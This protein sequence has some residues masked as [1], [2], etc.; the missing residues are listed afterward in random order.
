MHHTEETEEQ[1]Y[2]PTIWSTYRED[3]MPKAVVVA[4][5]A[6]AVGQVFGIGWLVDAAIVVG[7]VLLLACGP[8]LVLEYRADMKFDREHSINEEVQ[9]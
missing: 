7:A 3:L 8:A 4:F 5:V 2:P 9:A 1:A 6:L